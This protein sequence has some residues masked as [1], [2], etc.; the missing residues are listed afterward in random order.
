MPKIGLSNNSLRG[1][2]VVSGGSSA[3]SSASS[4]GLA[5]PGAANFGRG[6]PG[7]HMAPINGG[8]NIAAVTRGPG[9]GG[10]GLDALKAKAGEVFDRS[11]L[12]TNAGNQGTS[13]QIGNSG[14]LGSGQGNGG[15]G[16]NDKAPGGSNAKQSKSDGTS[17]AYELMKQNLQKQLELYWKEKEAMDPTLE[18]YKIRNAFAESL[19]TNVASALNSAFVTP[20][21]NA[22][23]CGV[24]GLQ[25]YNS[26][27]SLATTYACVDSN[28]KGVPISSSL[29][30]TCGTSS[31]TSA[32]Q[33]GGSTS[34]S[35]PQW[36]KDGKG[37]LT[38]CQG[39]AP[40]GALPLSNCNPAPGSTTGGGSASPSPGPS[41]VGGGGDH[42]A[43]I[44]ALAGSQ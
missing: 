26:N 35:Q 36:Q 43:A 27:C 14:G 39:V 13:P 31:G 5:A 7:S 29:I 19:A 32:G 17:L 2:G 25:G 34:N 4:G 41:V 30:G 15:T 16:A 12:A 3:T 28:G 22:V 21:M 9:Q 20:A 44:T 42:G 24:T 37:G 38:P 10:T 1:L 8:G 33:N 18:L 40:T 11:N 23:F 6:G